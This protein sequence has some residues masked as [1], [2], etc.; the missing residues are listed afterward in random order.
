[1]IVPKLERSKIPR[2]AR[3]VLERAPPGKNNGLGVNTVP[4]GV[5]TLD[6]VDIG[7]CTAIAAAV[8]VGATPPVVYALTY[9]ISKYAS[10]YRSPGPTTLSLY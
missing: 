5:M 9:L 1:M 2:S 7:L 4:T 6:I 3:F 10:L 8:G